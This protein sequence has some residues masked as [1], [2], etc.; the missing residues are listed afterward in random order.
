MGFHPVK[1]EIMR[2]D[3]TGQSGTRYKAQNNTQSIFID[4]DSVIR[5]QMQLIA[6]NMTAQDHSTPHKRRTTKQGAA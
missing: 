2:K 6:E 3:G 1:R 5:F 4:P